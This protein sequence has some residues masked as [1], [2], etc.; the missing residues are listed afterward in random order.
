MYPTPFPSPAQY[1]I[2]SKQVE[3]T[4]FCQGMTLRLCG[5]RETCGAIFLRVTLP[6]QKLFKC[7]LLRLVFFASLPPLLGRTRCVCADTKKNPKNVFVFLF[8]TSPQLALIMCSSCPIFS[9]SSISTF[10]VLTLRQPPLLFTFTF[11]PLWFGD[12][13]SQQT[14]A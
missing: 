9:L 14:S 8:Q 4:H 5:Q 3:V 12:A 7:S 2:P 6:D 13:Q 1:T 11:E 10:P